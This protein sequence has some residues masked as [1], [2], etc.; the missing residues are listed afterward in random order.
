[1]FGIITH[2]ISAR[3]IILNSRDLISEAFSVD[4]LVFT[5]DLKTYLVLGP[6]SQALQLDV[7][8][9]VKTVKLVHQFIY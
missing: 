3:I 6:V 7:R 1:M 8:L 2:E 9:L 5:R 4:T